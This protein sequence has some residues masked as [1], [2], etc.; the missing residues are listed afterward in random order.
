MP[1]GVRWVNQFARYFDLDVKSLSINEFE[2]VLVH[3]QKRIG[4]DLKLR[5]NVRWVLILP[6][7]A[8]IRQKGVRRGEGVYGMP[9]DNV[10]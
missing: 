1:L 5:E 2:R 9:Q 4:V 10:H 6:N 3:S 7:S 8:F